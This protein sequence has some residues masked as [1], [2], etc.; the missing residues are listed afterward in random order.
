[1]IN[2]NRRQ[3]MQAV[4][5]A[6]AAVGL[7]LPPTEPPV[8]EIV[9]SAVVDSPTAT[10]APFDRPYNILDLTTSAMHERPEVIDGFVRFVPDWSYQTWEVRI[11]RDGVEEE[12]LFGVDEKELAQIKTRDEIFAF[13]DGKL[14]DQHLV[15]RS[16]LSMPV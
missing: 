5:G 4:A 8:N 3:F 9:E 15:S 2:L 6:F 13:V 14:A 11:D 16:V 1:M 12:Y 10:I 7:G